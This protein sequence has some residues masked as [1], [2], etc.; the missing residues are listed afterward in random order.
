MFRWLIPQNQSHSYDQTTHTSTFSAPIIDQDGTPAYTV[1]ILV[2]PAPLP[3][4]SNRSA[5]PSG[6][7]TPAPREPTAAK[8]TITVPEITSL[9]LK[10]LFDSATDFLGTAPTSVVMSCPSFFDDKQKDALREVAKAAD[11][12]LVQ[13]LDET[14]AALVAYRV[15]LVEERKER[16]LLGSAEE[17]DAADEEVRDKTVVVVDLGETSLNVTVVQSGEGEYVELARHRD[18]SL[19]GRAFD[20]LV[21]ATPVSRTACCADPTGVV[22]LAFRQGVY[23]EDQGPIDSPLQGRLGRG[24]QAGG[25]EVETCRRAYKT[26]LERK[27]WLCHLCGRES[28]FES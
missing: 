5:A 26:K 18:D 2:P 3:T 16:G 27:L 25:D 13:L 14:A 24:R 22:V 20:D 12:P 7:A 6:A 11:I 1:D 4:P 28:C 23:Q 8:Q 15:G 21:S 9:F 17:G 19:G 10:T